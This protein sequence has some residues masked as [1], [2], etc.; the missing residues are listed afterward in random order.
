MKSSKVR[1]SAIKRKLKSF[2]PFKLQRIL[3]YFIKRLRLLKNLSKGNYSKEDIKKYL[4]D[5][6]LQNGD[7][8]IVHSSLGRIGYVQ[9]GAD[10]IIDSFLEIIG[11]EGLLV[12]PTFSSPTYDNERKV[13]MFDVRKTPAYTGKIP[14]TFRLRK[15]VKRSI[16]PMHSVAAC[17]KKAEWFVNGHEK[18]DN[19][20]AMNGPFGK[21][22]ELDA[23]IFQI[24]VDQLANSSI[25]I[26]EDKCKF[27]IKVFSDKLK[28][29]VV[30]E[31]GNK[32]IIEFRNHLPH[33]YKIRNNNMM[34]KHMLSDKIIKIYPF[35]NTEL[36]VT[37]V[38]D[39]VHCM[40]RLLEKGVTIYNS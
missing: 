28:A 4:I 9:G 38:R 15:N 6:R 14:D 32:K 24:G 11:R 39:F 35:G 5:A 20:Y 1:E 37:R 22:Y 23:K 3:Y 10:T 12:M 29:E 34:E 21:L 13:Y 18:C 27:P 19:P 30:D 36:R 26:V 25:H 40:E 2:V 8:V 33:L 31:N 16:S 7:M 17:G